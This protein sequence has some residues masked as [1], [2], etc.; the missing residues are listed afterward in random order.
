MALFLCEV[1]AVEPDQPLRILLPSGHPVA[2]F[3]VGGTVFVTDDICTH[4]DASLAEGLVDGFE[5]EC[6]YHMGRFD[7]RTGAAT[8][9]PCT[10][11]LKIH[12]VTLRDGGIYIDDPV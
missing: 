5:I 7:L 3:D 4:G 6:P 11:P 2:V 12:P 8:G 9:A 1:S 10:K